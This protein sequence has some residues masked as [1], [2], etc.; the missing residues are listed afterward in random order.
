MR[1][2]TIL[3]VLAALGWGGYWFVGSRGLDRAITAGL[4]RLPQV[5][6]DG[7]SVRGF[8]NRFDVTFDAPQ[9][10]A[11]GMQWSAPFA[12]VFALS[13]RLNHLLAVFANTQRLTG[14]GF[15]ATLISED[16]RASLVMEA[17][18]DLPLERLTLVGEALTLSLAGQSHLAD[19][20]RA[21]SRRITDT[22]QEVVILLENVYPDPDLMDRLDSQGLWPRAFQVLRLDGQV[23]TDRP[24]DRYLIGG[25]Q[26]RIVS[27]ALTGGRIAWA[28]VDITASGRLEPGADGLLSGDV[29]I[30]VTGYR[31]LLE[32]ARAAGWIP[33]DSMT[34][35]SIA[36]QSLEDPDDPE[37]LRADLT[38][39]NGTLRLG[40]LVLGQFPA[41][42]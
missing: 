13:Y 24:L 21:A 36:A 14:P 38:V 9:V 37:T 4:S 15:D 42:F 18:L 33:A 5:Q 20:L 22:R 3:A 2:L 10:Q 25:P 16:M 40:P 32:T 35:L 7:F 23:E 1:I 29:Q 30:S 28:G 41:L 19:T 17:G 34:M 8:P 12:Q 6:V 11:Q 26:P 39:A 27:A 31:A